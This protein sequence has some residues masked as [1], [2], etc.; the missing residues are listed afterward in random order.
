MQVKELG[1]KKV[2][3]EKSIQDLVDKFVNE[4]GAVGLKIQTNAK[5]Y[6]KVNGDK[7]LIGN[8]IKIIVNF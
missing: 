4:V 3:L 7:V 5:Y 8:D 2:E 1:Q 6:S